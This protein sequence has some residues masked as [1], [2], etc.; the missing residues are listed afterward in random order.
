MIFSRTG[1]TI[2]LVGLWA[3]RSFDCEDEYE[4]LIFKIKG[5]SMR[6]PWD[7]NESTRTD[8]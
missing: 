3:K 6:D 5:Q 8:R 7:I 4:P 1:L 2:I